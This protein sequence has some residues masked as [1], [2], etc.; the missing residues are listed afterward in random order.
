VE[1]RPPRALEAKLESDESAAER[2][3]FSRSDYRVVISLRE[4]YLAPLEGLKKTMPSLSQNRL[5]LA[6]MTGS[7][8]LEAVRRPGKDLVSEEV[9]AA[10][11]RF[12]AGGSELA[13][14]EVEPSLL[15]LICRELNEQ[16]IAQ[17]R[18]EVSLDLLAGS[19][20]SILS[21][22]YERSLAD[23]PAAVRR[24]IEDELLTDSGYRENLAE[25]RVL[26]RLQIAGAAP[27]ALGVLVNRRLLRIEE[28]LDVRRVELT[29]D[30]L[31]GVVKASRDQRQER[32]AREATERLLAEQSAR[33]HA[34]Q[35]ALRRARAIAAGCTA[36]AALA[37]VAA[38]LAIVNVQRARRAEA[39]A[40]QTRVLAEQGRNQAQRLLGFLTDDFVQEL[41]S[42]GRYQTIIGLS[43]REI[44]YF[45][46]LPP[47]LKDAQTVRDG[48][49]AYAN[50]AGA[51]MYLGNTTKG[52]QSA[53]TGIAL[54]D[55]LRRA[56]DRSEATAIAL[57]RVYTNLG[58][59]R[60][61]QVS[62]EEFTD[63]KRA[64]DLVRPIASQ[65]GASHEV[66]RAYVEVLIS[67]GAAG[68]GNNQNEDGVR[69]AREAQRLALQLG[70][71][72]P[73]D[74]V[75]DAD[76]AIAGSWLVQGLVNLRRSDEAHRAGE[77]TLQVI[78]R[79]LAQR[80]QYGEIVLAKQITES[81]LS[82]AASENLD[83]V[84]AARFAL[85]AGKTAFELV[86]LEPA[87]KFYLTEL[88]TSYAQIGAA[89][90]SAA[91]LR[92][93]IVNY[94]KAVDIYGQLSTSATFFVVNLNDQTHYTV[95]SQ[96]QLG[97]A[98]GAA[99]TLAIADSFTKKLHLGDSFPAGW[100][101][102]IRA[103]LT[104]TL[105]YERDDF[106]GARRIADDARVRWLPARTDGGPFQTAMK[107]Y[108]LYHLSDVEA[109]AEYRLGRFAVAAQLE[110]TAVQACSADVGLAT[111]PREVSQASTWLAMALAGTGQQAQAAQMIGPVV[112][113]YRAL[114]KRNHGDEWLPL[115]LAQ[116]LYAQ[117][118]TDER[119]APLLL[120]EAAQ[121]VDHL[122][123]TIAVLH[124]TQQWRARIQLAR[125]RTAQH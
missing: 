33:E 79:V 82:S 7:Q 21:S 29:H 26:R 6:P 47:K 117:S 38:V 57:A 52:I 23:Q 5:R 68:V 25:E 118:R 48:A 59:L 76:Y 1:N 40:Q 19:H 88:A 14:A 120:R 97:D 70:A 102:A 122:P 34:A 46:A 81:A 124:D 85:Q 27:D 95:V 56:G 110:R 115:E 4:D 71:R 60:A 45:N 101:N 74:L 42:F 24:V 87:N 108:A 72:N 119:Q 51:S 10:I 49:L 99:E 91:R 125:N 62:A 9:A 78:D 109:H 31:T 93:A 121:L 12:V 94:R 112:T 8:G 113:Q 61:N 18:S 15:S 63:I 36:L 90:W 28:R 32:E 83:A 80:P 43:Q 65:P 100:V 96:A 50:Y 58:K 66:R 37:V 67:S 111:R 98:A 104:A 114:E 106:A 77:D 123:P 69:S 105:A 30:V 64:A 39:D 107:N 16:R 11:V 53:T 3:D 103:Y 41:A 22:F 17:H 84:E 75:L 92:E 55:A 2:F 73:G 54:L 116:A 89:Q 86:A 20:E 44:D 13:N 35:R